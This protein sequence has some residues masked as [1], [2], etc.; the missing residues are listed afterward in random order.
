MIHQPLGGAQGQATDIAIQAQEILR[1]KEQLNKIMAS[2][3]GVTTKKIEKDTERDNFM[4]AKEAVEYG[5][6]DEVLEKS[7]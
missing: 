3:C 7:I 6:I 5:L 1:M 2:N 4:S